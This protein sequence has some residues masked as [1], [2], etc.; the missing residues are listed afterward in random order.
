M[1]VVCLLFVGELVAGIDN[2]AAVK[3]SVL[4]VLGS[5]HNGYVNLS[6]T[7]DN[8]VP[9][10]EV[11][12]SEKTKVEL[13]VLDGEGLASAEE[14]G[15]KV[16]VGVHAGVV[17][18]LVYVSTILCMDRTGVT[19]LML[20]CKVGDHLSHDVEKVVLEELEI[21]GIDIV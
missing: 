8:V 12:V 2:C 10:D 11:D 3:L 18:G 5:T 6:A 15:T 19:I 20:L 21:E 4:N 16:T 13:A 1:Y 9:V 17:A 14:A 7:S